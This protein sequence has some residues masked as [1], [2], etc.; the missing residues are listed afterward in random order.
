MTLIKFEFTPYREYEIGSR[1]TFKMDAE[2]Q[3]LLKQKQEENAV[4]RCMCHEIEG[5]GYPIIDVARL[6]S[7]NDFRTI[8]RNPN[9][10][11]DENCMFYIDMNGLY[12]EKTD[13]YSSIIFE[14]V[15]VTSTSTQAIQTTAIDEEKRKR[16]TFRHFC[17]DALVEASLWAFNSW[18][19]EKQVENISAFPKSHFLSKLRDTVLNKSMKNKLRARDSM[20]KYHFLSIGII[21]ETLNLNTALVKLQEWNGQN[22][23]LVNTVIDETRMRATVKLVTNQG[24][25]RTGPYV[26]IAVYKNEKIGEDKFQKIIVRLYVYSVFYEEEK[27]C[28]VESDKER[29]YA[30]KLLNANI[31]FY[32]PI[33][34]EFRRLSKSL[35]AREFLKECSFRPDFLEIRDKKIHVVEVCGYPNNADYMATLG[36]KELFYRFLENKS[37]GMIKYRKV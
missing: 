28:F 5:K 29:Q 7:D 20:P 15:I 10:Y 21:E 19:L 22:F 26:Y 13:K 6:P 4:L 1:T 32:K 8:R 16:F 31:G 3:N 37:I 35:P 24:N 17:F 14:E 30:K 18:N 34:D 25:V 12:A 36:R 9:Y 11:H 27:F 23:N 33:S 2:L